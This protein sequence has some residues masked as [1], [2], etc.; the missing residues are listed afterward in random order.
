MRTL[1]LVR[2][3]W[4]VLAVLVMAV[5]VVIAAA[6]RPLHA[7][8]A[9]NEAGEEPWAE[10]AAEG[11]PE[12]GLPSG[13]GAASA[14]LSGGRE[15]LDGRWGQRPPP[16]QG[17]LGER[18]DRGPGPLHGE[19]DGPGRR[20]PHGRG[21]EFDG[22]PRH[23][24]RG[25]GGDSDGPREQG[26][27]RSPGDFDGREGRRR[28][29]R[30][31]F[32]DTGGRGP[33]RQHGAFGGRGDVPSRGMP[34]R[35]GGPPGPPPPPAPGEVFDHMDSDGDGSVSREEFIEFHAQRRPPHF[36]DED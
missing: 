31:E 5:A 23:G 18:D 34:G 21:G 17:E 8:R 20:G 15:H 13:K 12:Q 35:S 26:P 16:P 1:R 9:G 14:R 25:R 28:P 27:Y 33:G 2:L 7:E 36:R 19:W 10:P 4:P 11:P 32:D 3:S 6:D 30:P 29:P 24:P 22:P